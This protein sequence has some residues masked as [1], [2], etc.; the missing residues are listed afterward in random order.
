[1]KAHLLKLFAAPRNADPECFF[2]AR[3]TLLAGGLLGSR[4]GIVGRNNARFGAAPADVLR[5]VCR[6]LGGGGDGSNEAVE[7]VS[8]SSRSGPVFMK[9][10]NRAIT[11]GKGPFGNKVLG[12]SVQDPVG[13]NFANADIRSWVGGDMELLILKCK[14]LIYAVGQRAPI[15][16]EMI[17]ALNSGP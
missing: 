3:L 10:C 17:S 13:E 2:A 16:G 12:F 8:A 11:H 9:P 4:S 6:G 14:G 5:L 1:M 15:R 7:N